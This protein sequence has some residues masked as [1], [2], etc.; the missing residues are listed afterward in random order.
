MIRES[1]DFDDCDGIA[2]V[3]AAKL[4]EEIRRTAREVVLSEL[5]EYAS[6][7]SGE[8]YG[9][10]VEDPN[11]DEGDSCWGFIRDTDYMLTEARSAIDYVISANETK[12]SRYE[13][14]S[15]QSR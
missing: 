13:L 2:Y 8:V 9:Y 12:V 1:K 6:Y 15:L 10:V 7:V 4:R 3:S 14:E 5:A 11:G